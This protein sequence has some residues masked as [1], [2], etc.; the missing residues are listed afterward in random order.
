[1]IKRLRESDG[2]DYLLVLLGARNNKTFVSVV[3][4]LDKNISFNFSIHQ[5]HILLSQ[6]V[7]LQGCSFCCNV[8]VVYTQL[9]LCLCQRKISKFV[10]SVF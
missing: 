10:I 9:S 4:K 7:P 2:V 3:G 5:Y 1:M 8:L 6:L